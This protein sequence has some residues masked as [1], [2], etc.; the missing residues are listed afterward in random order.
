MP[1]ELRLRTDALEWFATNPK[2]WFKFVVEA[3]SDVEE[4]L[5]TPEFSK[6][7]S[8]ARN[9]VCLMPQAQTRE[10]YLKLAPQI[11]ELCKKYGFRFSPRLQIEV[12]DRRVGV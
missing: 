8:M 12:Y 9:R 6:L 3:E 5:S 11:I 7:L 2:A 10:E 4:M 1:R